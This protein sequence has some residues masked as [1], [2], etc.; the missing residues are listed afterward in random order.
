MDQQVYAMKI[1]DIFNV[2]V[3]KKIFGSVNKKIKSIFPSPDSLYS[4]DIVKK[5][6]LIHTNVNNFNL[7]N[8]IPANPVINISLGLTSWSCNKNP[9]TSDINDVDS[10]NNFNF[11]NSKKKYFEE[12]NNNVNN[13][14]SCNGKNGHL[15]KNKKALGK[16]QYREKIIS[17]SISNDNNT[18]NFKNENFDNFIEINKSK[19]NGVDGKNALNNQIIP[20]ADIN[21][22]ETTST[23]SKDDNFTTNNKQGEM[24]MGKKDEKSFG[25][26]IEII[27]FDS[28]KLSGLNRLTN[29]DNI[30]CQE[31]NNSIFNSSNLQAFTSNGSNSNLN[32][33]K[34]LFTCRESSRFTFVDKNNTS[35]S[36]SNNN[37]NNKHGKSTENVE[38]P[39]FVLELI[40]KKISRQWLTKKFEFMEDILFC[41]ELLQKE[42]INENHW[43]EFILEHKNIDT[44]KELI[45]DFEIINKSLKHKFKTNYLK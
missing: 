27:K 29:P 4:K 22:N 37:R 32:N 21:S 11:P 16:I 14:G 1:S 17:S 18:N 34:N 3:R 19:L 20:E 25:E 45:F 2:D 23:S 40:Q 7:N 28:G 15:G 5:H 12:D 13:A 38:I 24:L 10:N 43:A 36:N 26:L 9:T 42:Y 41:D 33:N 44:D 6:E 8:N 39:G 30:S 35:Q 31:V